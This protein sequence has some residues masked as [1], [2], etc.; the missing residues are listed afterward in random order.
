MD[1]ADPNTTQGLK[2][3]G[4]QDF[5]IMNS[6]ILLINSLTLRLV[7]QPQMPFRSDKHKV[8]NNNIQTFCR[9]VDKLSKI[10]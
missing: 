8:I 7:I 9:L 3:K 6:L 5:M 2:D 1:P 10:T 4:A